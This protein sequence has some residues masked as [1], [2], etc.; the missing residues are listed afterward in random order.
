M[1]AE[2]LLDSTAAGV[3]ASSST[4]IQAVCLK[5]GCQWLPGT[6]QEKQIRAL[7]G[8]LGEGAQLI[9]ER[10][11]ITAKDK[12]KKSDR[13]LRIIIWVL[14]LTVLGLI[15]LK[16]AMDNASFCDPSC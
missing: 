7:S 16:V 11:L 10:A 5:C 1:L 9:A 4:V 8:Q 14:A 13:T 15:V 3:A 2:A 12:Q 6:E